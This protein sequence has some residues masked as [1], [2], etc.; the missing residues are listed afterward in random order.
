MQRLE[1]SLSLAS[2]NA[3]NKNESNNHLCHR[4]FFQRNC[5]HVQ[6]EFVSDETRAARTGLPTSPPRRYDEK[7]DDTKN[8]RW[9]SYGTKPRQRAAVGSR[10]RRRLSHTSAPTIIKE[11]IVTS[12]SSFRIIGIGHTPPFTVRE[13]PWR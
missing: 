10:K 1:T 9:S 7:N 2:S 8:L 3:W 6:E 5:S 12:S 4:H 13:T 11:G